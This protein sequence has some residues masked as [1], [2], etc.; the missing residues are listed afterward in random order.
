[1]PDSPTAN[2]VK[3]GG[4]AIVGSEGATVPSSRGYAVASGGI[5]S[6]LGYV[7][8][9]IDGVSGSRGYGVLANPALFTAS[10]TYALR[11]QTA[12][13]AILAAP[14]Y[15]LLAPFYV[16]F[17]DLSLDL[18]FVEYRFP[19]CVSFGSQGGPGFKT[20][21]FAFDSG[22]VT[23]QPEWDR[24]RARYEATFENATPAD[25]QEVEEFFYGVRGRAIGFR[26]KD[27]SD[28]Q[29]TNQNIAVGDGTTY[30]FQLFKR[31]SSGGKIF[32][33]IIKKT[34]ADTTEVTIDGVTVLEGSDYFMLD[35]HGQIVF[36]EAP[37]AGSLIRMTYGEFDVPVR[38]DSDYLDVSF[39]DFRQ[40]SLSIPLIE[41]LL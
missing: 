16:P 40:L 2:I 39:D 3:N 30:Q 13:S 15:A 11:S 31:Y 37:A 34:V 28:Y 27:W 22:A 41:V 19:E 38:F 1:M 7:A 14:G 29:I 17:E 18:S 6:G 25:I 10:N 5:S 12:N 9:R 35:A 32:D 26:Y 20:S 33:R 24:M 21:V 36:P 8:G 4:Y 23:T